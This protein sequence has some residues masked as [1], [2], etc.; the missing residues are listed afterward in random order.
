MRIIAQ[1]GKIVVEM[2]KNKL[3]Y[4]LI[5]A[6]IAAFC[7]AW[8]SPVSA[9]TVTTRAYLS[10][11]K[12]RPGD[13]FKLAVVGT[14][15]KGVHIG[16]HDKAADLPATLAMKA[17]KGVSFDKPVYPKAV[18][19]SFGSGAG[20]LPVYEG[21]FA[22]RVIG[23]VAK[24]AKLGPVTIVTEL[25]TQACD[26][27]QCFLPEVSSAKAQT[28]I[29]GRGELAKQINKK[30]FASTAGADEAQKMCLRLAGMGTIPRLL[31]LY[32]IGL[33]LAFTPCVYPMIPVTV[34]YFSA[35]SQ[36]QR[37]R[38]VIL[39]AAVY[40]LGLALTYSVLGAV[41]ALT[42]G[43]FG[44]A[45]QK[46]AVLV[47]IA[48]LLAALALSM[49][50]LFELRPPAFV[51]S[52]ASGRSGVL[53]ALM[54]GLIFGIVA[55]PCVGPAVLGLMAYVASIGSPAV[56]F[57][58]FFALSL[59]IGTPLFFLAAF[60]ARMPVPGMWMVA[61][62]KAAG[63]MMLG[64][65]AYFLLPILPDSIGRYLIPA[66]LVIGGLYLGFFEKSIKSSRVTA[67]VG[68]AFGTAAL[69]FAIF[70]SVP[71]ISV[72]HVKWQPYSPEKAVQ[73]LDA[74][75]PIAIDF[76]AKWCTVCKELERG[77]FS[78]KRVVAAMDRFIRLRVDGTDSNDP[79]VV[80]ARKLHHVNG[81]P[82]VVFLDT[83]GREVKS[84]RI[85]TNIEP[86][87]VLARLK[88][89]E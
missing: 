9:A 50:G 66:I 87:E 88:M 7:G 68:K 30:I 54:M 35:Q 11:D 79:G 15:E 84:A 24:D 17:P 31:L 21:K 69:I 81:Y 41:A 27:A 39:L 55:A 6:V 23:R 61:V 89:V 72:P 19:K 63:F 76:T 73:A 45:M 2:N 42:G 38:K 26:N 78:D 64:A 48:V 70:M 51:T 71:R 12:L 58:L 83:K 22:I 49:F 77:A 33:I 16:A 62:K 75:K 53:G 47:G 36:E 44:A 8:A 28:E 10:V 43:A 60:S 4:F 80:A 65:A 82:T 86:A 46:P 3:S 85:I 37:D 74:G 57:G 1:S 34:G 40:V 29:V 32:V 59:G 5:I 25:E 52:R 67:H 20:K 56:G 14:V 13:S 18:R